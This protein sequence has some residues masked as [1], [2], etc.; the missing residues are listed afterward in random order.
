LNYRTP[1][2]MSEN[3]NLT[4]STF[5]ENACQR[6]ASKIEVYFNVIY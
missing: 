5:L 3:Y 6:G 4:I 2:Q 1:N